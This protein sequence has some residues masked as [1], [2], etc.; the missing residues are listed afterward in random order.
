MDTDFEAALRRP[1][2]MM[3]VLLIALFLLV[4]VAG[5]FF[6]NR[7]QLL[8]IEAA[9]PE[10]FPTQGFS[11]STFESLL[12]RFVD[13]AGRVDYDRWHNDAAAL[14]GLDS[15]L[16]AVAAHSPVNSPARFTKKSDQL[17]YWLYAYNA[18]VVRNV[19]EHWPLDSVTHLKA[20][21]EIVTGFGFF[22]QQR[23]LFGGEAMSLYSVE[24]DVIRSTYRD[25]RIHFVLNCASESCPIMRPDLPTGSEL[26]PFLASATIAFISDRKNVAIEHEQRRIILSD[27]F[28]WYKKDFV[29]D[30]RRQGLPSDGGLIEYLLSAAPEAM[31][32]DLTA[33][34]DYEIEF[35]DYDWSINDTETN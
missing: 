33:A 1:S 23:F 29:N 26:E 12:H 20:P 2:A 28:K 19:L 31:V 13:D 10:D 30:L 15:Y 24:N 5:F 21:L 32:A 17:A 34:R 7:P 18:Y 27:I 25:P 11:H 4:A 14:S 35:S 6:V 22:W 9:L 3:Y 8:I 16:A